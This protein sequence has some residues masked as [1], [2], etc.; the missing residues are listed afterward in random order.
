MRKA[1]A[2]S[3]EA[4]LSDIDCVS[5][6]MRY[7]VAMLS[8]PRF[9]QFLFFMRFAGLFFPAAV[10]AGRKK[11]PARPININVATSDELQQVPGIGPSTAEKVLQMRKC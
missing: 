5:Y 4:F 11:S 10:L 7:T 8:R 9:V 1:S 3:K 2:W 6:K